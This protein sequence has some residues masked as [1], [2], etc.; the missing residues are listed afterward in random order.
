MNIEEQL[1]ILID[2]APQYGVPAVVVEKAIAPV[3]ELFAKQLSSTEY[4]VLQNLDSNWVLTTIANPQL[5]QE[6]Q[7]IY[8]FQT[9]KDAAIYQQ[10]SNPDLIA[11][12]MPITHLLF[13][14]FSLRQ[15]ESL[16]VLDN[17][18]NLDRGIEIRRDR[19]VALIQQQIK[20]LT[21]PPSNIA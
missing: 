15:V 3:L 19:L 13:R 20:Q 9:V 16:I 17:S 2:D 21:Q 7:V 14:L 4:Y 5:Q 1:K 11:V 10:K 12:P 8:A 18:L 6:K